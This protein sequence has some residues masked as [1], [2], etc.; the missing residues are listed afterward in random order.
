MFEYSVDLVENDDGSREL[1]CHEGENQDACKCDVMF[2]EKMAK[3]NSQCEVNWCSSWFWQIL[4]LKQISKFDQATGVENSPFCVNEDFRTENGGGSFDPFDNS[5]DGCLKVNM[6]DHN[7]KDA[8]CGEY[9]DRNCFYF[10]YFIAWFY[11]YF[12]I[13]GTWLLTFEK[14]LKLFD[15]SWQAHVKWFN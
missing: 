3:V 4:D 2:A 13:L 8:C 1:V 14:N 10:Y 11:F 15:S 5:A 6:D 9:P 12:R 7:A